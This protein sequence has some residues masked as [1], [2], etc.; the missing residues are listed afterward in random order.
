MSGT[1]PDA[2][3]PRPDAALAAFRARVRTLPFEARLLSLEVSEAHPT[4]PGKVVLQP[5]DAPE[6]EALADVP[7]WAGLRVVGAEVAEQVLADTL[8]VRWDE[9]GSSVFSVRLLRRVGNADPS[10]RLSVELLAP[11][12][13]SARLTDELRVRHLGYVDVRR[14]HAKTFKHVLALGREVDP[15]RAVRLPLTFLSEDPIESR[16]W[17]VLSKTRCALVHQAEGLTGEDDF[18]QQVCQGCPDAVVHELDPHVRPAARRL[19][20]VARDAVVDPASSVATFP[21]GYRGGARGFGFADPRGVLHLTRT[22]A[23]GGEVATTTYLVAGPGEAR[24]SHLAAERRIHATV[25]KAQG[26][27]FLR[28]RNQ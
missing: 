1:S 23:S 8:A 17:A 25:R 15:D 6:L 7:P 27:T 2:R 13:A 26:A 11:H 28:T 16:D 24:P 14:R 19:Q 21:N 20:E 3:S 22:L 10:G 9:L 18:Y 4:R 12:E 5:V